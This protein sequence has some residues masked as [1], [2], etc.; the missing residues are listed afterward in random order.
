LGWGALGV[1]RDKAIAPADTGAIVEL[2]TTEAAA[3]CSIGWTKSRRLA[4]DLPN[5]DAP[6][7]DKRRSANMIQTILSQ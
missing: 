1:E 2:C 6:A 5:V 4:R 7:V 3:N